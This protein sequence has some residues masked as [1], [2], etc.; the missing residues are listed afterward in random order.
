MNRC[1]IFLFCLLLVFSKVFAQSS[2]ETTKEKLQV[3]KEMIQQWDIEHLLDSIDQERLPKAV[4]GGVLGMANMSNFIITNSS[5]DVSSYMKVGGEIGGFI[6]FRVTKHFAIQGRAILT[7]EQNR[8]AIS[9]SNQRLWSF[10]VDIPLYF[11]GRFGNMEKGYLQFGAGPFTHFTF[12]SN[13]SGKY[14]NNTAQVSVDPNEPYAKLYVLHDNHFGVSAT[15]GYELPLGI[16]ILLDYRV[17]LSDILS[18]YK[19]E[20]HETTEAIYP[21]RLSLGIGYRWK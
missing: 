16:Q 3:T 17:S 1:K 12:A 5:D 13:V 9:E 8:F 10:G 6:D 7:A 14:T 19:Q 18:Y 20:G 2:L 21:Q 4:T 15:I 11:L